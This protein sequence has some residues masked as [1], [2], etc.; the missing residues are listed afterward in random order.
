MVFLRQCLKVHTENRICSG[1]APAGQL[2]GTVKNRLGFIGDHQILICHQLEAETGAIRTGTG[3]I[4][5]REH[6]GL[7]LRQTDA[8]VL[9]GI[10]LGK[11]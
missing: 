5:E 8:A 1:T 2:D 9:T 10:I 7:Q 11:T 3:G 4:I 6:S